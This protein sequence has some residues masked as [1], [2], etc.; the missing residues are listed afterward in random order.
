MEEI[1]Q[2]FRNEEHSFIDKVLE[3]KEIVEIQYRMK[4]TDFLD[5]REQFIIKSIIGHHGEVKVQ[6]FGGSEHVE[7]K[8]AILYPE[9]ITP[10]IEDYQISVFEVHYPKKFVS[11]EHRQVLG[12]LMSIGLKRG[13]YGDIL[14]K[15]DTVQI[16]VANEVESFV[17]LQFNEVGRQSVSLQPVPFNQIVKTNESLEEKSTTISSLRLDAV[18]SA[19]YNLS[20]QK[21][22]T[23]IENGFVKVNWKKI[24]DPAFEVF[25]ED[26]ISIR[27]YGR[28]KVLD[29][30]GKTKKDKWKVKV[31]YVK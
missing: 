24:E 7:R 31:G 30:E 18:C 22:K 17:K 8:R 9:Y 23:F 3:W 28:A 14:I 6:F 4:L 11:L 21:T 12:A 19:I 16:I 29:I 25:V 15:D 10:E 1:Y 13:K 20:R 26:L 27:G 5:P 2:H